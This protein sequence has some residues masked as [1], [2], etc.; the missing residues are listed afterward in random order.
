MIEFFFDCSSPWTYIAFR[1]VQSLAAELKED[2]VWRPV[3]VGGIFNS[4][5]PAVYSARENM[6]TA[7]NRYMLKDVQDNAREAGLKI[8]FP[9][10][11]FPVNSVKAMR[12]CLWLAKDVQDP[13]HYLSFVEET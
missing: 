9:P 13:A 3:L 4:V 11:V 10:R 2:I 12:G 7:R 8:A 1:N 6:D 5:N